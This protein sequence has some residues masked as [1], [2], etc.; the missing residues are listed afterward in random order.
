MNATR[1]PVQVETVNGRTLRIVRT[2]TTHYHESPVG[3]QWQ[4][5]HHNVLRLP[6]DRVSITRTET[7][8]ASDCDAHGSRYRVTFRVTGER[9][10]DYVREGLPTAKVVETAPGAVLAEWFF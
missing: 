2:R 8:Y 10:A 4:R 3:G 1:R 6:V 7:R 9:A 5:V